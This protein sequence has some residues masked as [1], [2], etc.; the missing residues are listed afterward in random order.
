MADFEGE[1]RELAGDVFGGIVKGQIG[2]G[3]GRSAG[4][5]VESAVRRGDVDAGDLIRGAKNYGRAAESDRKK[6]ER[7]AEKAARALEKEQQK[8]ERLEEPEKPSR[9]EQED[10]FEKTPQQEET[11]PQ[12]YA[13]EPTYPELKTEAAPVE[14]LPSNNLPEGSFQQEVPTGTI[15]PTSIT[16]AYTQATLAAPSAPSLKPGRPE[17]VA[18]IPDVAKPQTLKASYDEKVT[19]IPDVGSDADWDLN[20]GGAIQKGGSISQ[21]IYDAYG[22]GN[23]YNPATGEPANGRLDINKANDFVAKQSG[24]PDKDKVSVGQHVHLPNDISTLE[25]LMKPDTPEVK[26]DLSYRGFTSNMGQ[27]AP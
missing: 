17:P 19:G 6:E 23:F 13:S 26:P 7:E 12:V 16:P 18:P 8:L 20:K 9:R 27:I 25:R 5:I 4:R 1:L 14:A 2:D 21:M 22:E 3:K 24:I 15:S 11:A 10:D